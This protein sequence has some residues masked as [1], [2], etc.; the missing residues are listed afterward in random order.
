ME[1]KKWLNQLK[2]QK[3]RTFLRRF[4]SKSSDDNIKNPW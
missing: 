1:E 4:E 2:D 3:N